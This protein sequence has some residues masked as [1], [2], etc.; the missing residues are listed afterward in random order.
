MNIRINKKTHKIKSANQL[1]CDEYLNIL[2]IENFGIIEYLAHFTGYSKEQLMKAKINQLHLNTISQV[3]GHIKSIDSFFLI[4]KL[5]DEIFIAG[6]KHNYN[7][8]NE[9]TDSVGARLLLTQKEQNKKN[10]NFESIVY[11][12]AIILD[13]SMDKDN[14][15]DTFEKLLKE[16]YEDCFKIACFF[17]RKFQS[18]LSKEMSYLSRLKLKIKTLTQAFGK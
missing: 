6:S 3:I 7:D 8:L 18:Q 9:L 11:F 5:P 2:Q 14:I 17:L 10:R 16:N 15:N 12:L 4:K 1:T 13:G